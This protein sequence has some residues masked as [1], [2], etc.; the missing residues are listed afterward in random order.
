MVRC[1]IVSKILFQLLDIV[2]NFIARIFLIPFI[3]F[4][5]WRNSSIFVKL[6]G[7]AF[8]SGQ[9]PQIYQEQRLKYWDNTI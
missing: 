9:R 7:I 4:S 8:I 3:S 1:K 5:E 2:W 6:C